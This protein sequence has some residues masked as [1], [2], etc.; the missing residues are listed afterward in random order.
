MTMAGT[1]MLYGIR[2]NGGYGLIRYTVRHTIPQGRL[3]ISIF[4]TTK[5]HYTDRLPETH[6]E[7]YE[8]HAGSPSPVWAGAGPRGPTLPP[9]EAG[10]LA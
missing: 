4:I 2:E 5:I 9:L 7:H 8:A 1:T 3:F 10:A 6:S